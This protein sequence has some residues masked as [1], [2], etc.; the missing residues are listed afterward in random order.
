MLRVGRVTRMVAGGCAVCHGGAQA[1]YNGASVAGG[2]ILTRPPPF[3]AFKI[4][5]DLAVP[6][7]AFTPDLSFLSQYPFEAQAEI[8]SLF[9]TKH[10]MVTTGWQT[11]WMNIAAFCIELKSASE[12]HGVPELFDQCLRQIGP[13]M[14]ELKEMMKALEYYRDDRYRALVGSKV[15]PAQICAIV[16]QYEAEQLEVDLSKATKYDVVTQVQDL[17]FESIN[18]DDVLPVIPA[19]AGQTGEQGI[20]AILEM[21]GIPVQDQFPNAYMCDFGEMKRPDFKV[22]CVKSK[23][24]SRLSQGFYI[25]STQRLAKSSNK[26]LGLF[27]L[28]HQVV[29]YADLPTIVV[30]DGPAISDRV[31]DWAQRFKKK[32]EKDHRLFAVVTHQQFREWALRKLGGQGK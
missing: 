8:K 3:P 17:S 4:V 5:M 19:I 22:G 10:L 24:D 28:L 15:S 12:K 7:K 16:R 13:G 25:E 27:Y 31:W 30:F 26:D 11:A 14:G 21:L 20:K 32:H 9:A 18:T 6:D 29:R 1:S 2:G 23:C